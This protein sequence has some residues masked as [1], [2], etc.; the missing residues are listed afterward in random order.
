MGTRECR[1]IQFKRNVIRCTIGI[2]MDTS[3]SFD[4][5]IY[6][7]HYD[8]GVERSVQILDEHEIFVKHFCH[9]D[10]DCYQNLTYLVIIFWIFLDIFDILRNQSLLY[11]LRS[12]VHLLQRFWKKSLC[13]VHFFVQKNLFMGNISVQ[14][15]GSTS[16][17]HQCI[18][19]ELFSCLRNYS[20]LLRTIFVWLRFISKAEL[21]LY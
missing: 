15:P 18:S 19:G 7:C 4:T 13:L 1:I 8:V 9:E 17:E 12:I 21:K 11:F 10:T 14:Q 6:V 20:R 3:L 16:K 5:E 2:I